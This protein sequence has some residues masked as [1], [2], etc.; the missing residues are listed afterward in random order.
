MKLSPYTRSE[1]AGDPRYLDPSEAPERL[2]DLFNREGAISHCV[3]PSPGVR[4]RIALLLTCRE[5]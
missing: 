3:V 1:P 5:T 2:H 4:N